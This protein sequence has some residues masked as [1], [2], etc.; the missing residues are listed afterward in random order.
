[1]TTAAGAGV[2]QQ[3]DGGADPSK[4]EYQVNYWTEGVPSEKKKDFAAAAASTNGRRQRHDHRRCYLHAPPH[5]RQTTAE[6]GPSPAATSQRRRRMPSEQSRR[7]GI[8][9]PK[10][11]NGGAAG[12][13]MDLGRTGERG[14]DLGS[15]CSANGWKTMTP[16]R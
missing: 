8:V 9:R 2:R 12:G 4:H 5:S 15:D 10:A 13:V 6:T 16:R 14:E 1:M 3:Q 7:K 11:W